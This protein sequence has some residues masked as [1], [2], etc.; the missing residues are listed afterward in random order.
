M[1]RKCMGVAMATK[2]CERSDS[3]EDVTIVEPGARADAS[4]DGDTLSSLNEEEEDESDEEEED[5]SNGT[6]SEGIDDE[7]ESADGS[8]DSF[9]KRHSDS[10]RSCARRFGNGDKKKIQK[11]K[12]EHSERSKRL[13][14]RRKI[15][16]I[17]SDDDLDVTRVKLRAKNIDAILGNFSTLSEEQLAVPVEEKDTYVCLNPVTSHG[18]PPTG[19]ESSDDAPIFVYKDLV[20]KLKP[21]HIIGARFQWSH[22]TVETDGFDC[23]LAAFMGMGKTLQVITTVQAFLSKKV[24]D[25]DGDLMPRYQ[26]VLILAPNICAKLGNRSRQVAWQ[27]EDTTSWDFDIRIESRKENDGSRK[28]HK[29]GGILVM[30]YELYQLL[31]LQSTNREKTGL[32][33]KK[34][35]HSIKLMYSCLSDSGPDLIVLDEGH[36]VLS[37][38]SKMVKALAHFKT[39]RR[40]I[41]TGYSLQNHLEEHWTMVNF[42]RPNYL[43]SLEEFKNRYVSP[44][45]NGQC[46]DSSEADLRLARHRAFF[47]TR[48][49]K[50]FVLRRDQKYLFTQVPP[51]KEYVIM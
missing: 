32:S 15:A 49:L 33:D 48:E 22:I 10:R 46:I 23:V 3:E 24:K 35:A 43:G 37:H 31:V 25:E 9:F 6:E 18:A 29:R 8:I 47:L 36:R 44:I 27:K 11:R 7:D 40:I 2:R 51:K 28:W 42:A 5:E 26:H 38:K 16:D 41:L 20:E 17:M 13:N 34:H 12:I 1:K 14:Q 50:P 39:K 21:H 45:T 30:A 4:E 19:D